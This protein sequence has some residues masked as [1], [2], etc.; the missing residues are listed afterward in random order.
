MKL[1]IK[2]LSIIALLISVVSCATTTQPVLP[3]RYDFD[4]EF[5]ALQSTTL[6]RASNWEQVDSQSVMLTANAGRHYLLVLDRPLERMDP[7]IGFLGNR[8][9]IQAGRDRI[10]VGSSANRLTYSIE[11][12]YELNGIDEAM[13]VKEQL[14]RN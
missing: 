8:S 7:S 14:S 1:I 3:E 2:T 5:R 6:L 13:K 11:K 12:I 4:S 10:Y 9:N